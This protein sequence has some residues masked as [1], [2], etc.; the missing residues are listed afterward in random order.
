MKRFVFVLSLLLF[1]GI[2]LLQAQGV[3]VSGNV[4]GA[5]DFQQPEKLSGTPLDWLPAYRV[6]GEGIFL[7]LARDALRDWA[8]QA[9]ERIKTLVEHIGEEVRN[10]LTTTP[11]LILLHSLAHVLIRRFSFEAGYGASSIRERIYSAP[12]NSRHEMGGILIYTAA[13]DSDGTMGGL[14]RLGRPKTFE[15]TLLNAL[16]DARWCSADPICRESPGQGVNSDNL[17]ACHA[18]SLLPE[19]SCEFSNRYLDRM[20]L[21]GEG[22]KEGNG[23][24]S[25][26]LS[27]QV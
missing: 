10:H 24:F 11:E 3:Q 27:S 7:T 25:A 18:C 4:T 8:Q 1:V 22:E 6:V 23:F 15:K 26:L 16:A 21:L 17:A 5:D 19:T 13:G 12:V 2:N 20:T 9:G 14:V